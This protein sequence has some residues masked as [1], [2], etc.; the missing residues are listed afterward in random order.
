MVCTMVCVHTIL[1]DLAGL[2]KVGRLDAYDP[3]ESFQIEDVIKGKIL[4]Q[5]T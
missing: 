4:W 3:L 5:A 2:F 1:R